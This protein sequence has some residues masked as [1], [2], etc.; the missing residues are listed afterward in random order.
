M[1]NTMKKNHI[2]RPTG[3][4]IGHAIIVVLL[5]LLSLLA[6]YPFWHVVMYSV[7][8]SR[9]AMV[10][11]L[12][13]LPRGFTLHSYKMLLS[14][15]QIFVAY[16]NSTLQTGI[17]VLLSIVITVMTAFPLTQQRFRGRRAFNF[18]F[19]LTMIFQC[20]M[21]P[22]F[23]L[24][25]SLGL[26]DTFWALII[27]QLMTAYNMFVIKNYMM[28]VPA[29]LA[30]SAYLDGAGP[31]RTLFKIIVPV[32]APVIAAVTMFY[33]VQYWNSYK[34]CLLYEN[35]NTYQNLQMYLRILMNSNTAMD[36]VAGDISASQKALLTDETVKMTA[37]SISVIPVLIF[38][39]FVQR[40]YTKG[41][42]AGAVKE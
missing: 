33:M 5:T 34:E 25:K 26:I 4:K 14:T 2:K 23:L 17:G 31:F 37:V 7:S 38:Y 32:C 36:S 20:G 3:E 16:K 9:K 30:E 1:T 10:G 29:S 39:P 8:D 18:I 24:V 19:S 15:Q 40:Y 11:G 35:S 41:I 6:I 21:I 12:F 42:V 22:T 13:L 28:S 27:P